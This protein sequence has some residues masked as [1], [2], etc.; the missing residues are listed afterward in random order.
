MTV[1]E[2]RMRRAQLIIDLEDAESDLAFSRDKARDMCHTMQT[3]I[4]TLQHSIEL[5]PSSRDF[6]A[7]GELETRLSLAQHANFVTVAAAGGVIS[8]M[9]KCRQSVFNLRERKRKLVLL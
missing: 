5:E 8:E 2:K 7:D 1:D 6:T 4:D 3:V 9:K